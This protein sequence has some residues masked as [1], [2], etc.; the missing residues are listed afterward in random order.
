MKMKQL[1]KKLLTTA[2]GA[3]MALGAASQASAAPDFTIDPNAIPG[4]VFATNPF[5]A[6]FIQGTSSELINLT[7]NTADA[8]GYLQFTAFTNDASAVGPLTSGLLVD[9]NL[10]VTYD[11]TLTLQSGTAGQPG[12]VYTIDTLNFQ[13]W[14]DPD[15]NTTFDPANLPNDDANVAGITTDDILLGFS[16][17]LIE[18]TAG[19]NA[20]GGVFLN[21]INAFAICTGAGTATVGGVPILAPGCTSGVGDAFFAEPTPFYNL[22]FGEFNNTTQGLACNTERTIC[23]VTSAS[24]GVDF[25]STSVPEPAS[26]ALLGIGLAGLGFSLRRRKKK[27]TA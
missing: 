16:A 2:V 6:D 10:Y 1:R 12:S 17:G 25:N 8:S 27:I 9:Y 4:A 14:A 20:L 13:V 24:G 3:V 22:V 11:L 21:S 19:F 5:V 18:G 7:G 15:L 23:A 26:L